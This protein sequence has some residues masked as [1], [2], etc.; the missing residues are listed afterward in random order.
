MSIYQRI[1]DED[2]VFS[3]AEI[4]VNYYDIAK[5]EGLS[6]MEAAKLMIDKANENGADAVKFQTYKA[7]KIAS[8]NSPAYWDQSEEPT[9]SQ[10]ELFTKFD[11]FG[12]AE[13][14]ELAAYCESTEIIFMST[15][16][17]FQAVDYLNDLMPIYKISSSDITNLPFIKYMAEK[18]KP[19]FLSTGASTLGEIEKAV[20][21]IVETGNE[22]ICLMHCVLDYPT[23]Y[24]DA[25]LNMIK[26]L[27]QVF[28]DYLLGFSDHTRPDDTMITLTTAYLY[29]AKVIEKHFTLDKTL[30]GNDHYHAMDPDDLK[31]FSN[32]LSLIKKITGDYYKH[33]LECEAESRKQARRSIVAKVNIN[34]GDIVS[35]E[36]ITFK[37]P[38]T[39]ISPDDL[40]MVIGRVAREKVQEDELIKWT[41]IEQK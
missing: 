8:K 29:G 31:K 17:D 3:I 2:E 9:S 34:K 40:D 38:G 5:K 30:Q 15:P 16:F 27:G 19:V 32:N 23:G 26:H 41:N 7:G 36:K 37:R 35:R 12:Q 28:P 14:E 13:Y 4:G 11:K 39:G 24:E 1:I 6:L 22:E 20:N 21:T 25:N 10:Y 18:G 33:P